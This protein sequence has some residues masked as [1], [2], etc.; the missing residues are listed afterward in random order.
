MSWGYVKMRPRFCYRPILATYESQEGTRSFA[1]RR[2]VSSEIALKDGRYLS[3]QVGMWSG[4]TYLLKKCLLSVI[5][6]SLLE[7][8]ARRHF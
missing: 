1:L 7:S 3:S 5:D 2:V 4:R 6:S 8:L